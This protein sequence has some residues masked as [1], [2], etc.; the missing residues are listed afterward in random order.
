MS[1]NSILLTNFLTVSDIKRSAAF[2]VNVLGGKIMRDGQPTVIQLYNGA[3]VLD[4]GGGPT[5]DKPG[6]VLS[7]PKN[8][9]EAGGFM[10]LRVTD[11]QAC[12]KD[13]SARGAHFLTEPKADPE[14][15]ENPGAV[16]CFMR[17]PDGY[18]IQVS[19][20]PA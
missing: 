13:W 17:D 1:V 6:V 18:L 4:L 5:I 10:N 9:D 7:P 16:R 8:L 12:Y 20:P 11:I 14:P 15:E 3:I 19:Q 2:Y